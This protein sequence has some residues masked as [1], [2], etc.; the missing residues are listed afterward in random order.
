MKGKKV[1]DPRTALTAW[2]DNAALCIRDYLSEDYGFGCE[3]DEINDSYFIAAANACDESVTLSTGGTQPRYTCNGVVDTASV[4][5]DNLTQ[6]VS[7]LAGA[8]TYVQ[9]QFR[10][11]AGAYDSPTD[12]IPTSM[13]AGGVKLRAPHAAQE[14]FNAVKGTYVDPGKSWQPT[15]FPPVTNDTYEDQDNGEQIFKD[16]ELPFTTHPERARASRRSYWRR[17]GRGWW[18]RCRSTTRG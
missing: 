2:S 12:D 16:V 1:Y 7:S 15:D 6:L 4:P 11:H 5:L 13:L 3:A 8:V 14:L 9:G 17:R 18:S 10:A